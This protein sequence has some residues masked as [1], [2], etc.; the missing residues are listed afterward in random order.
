LTIHGCLIR[1]IG[2][3][4]QEFLVDPE[5]KKSSD[6][7]DD[8]VKIKKQGL[9]AIKTNRKRGKMNTDFRGKIKALYSYLY[10]RNNK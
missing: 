2:F 5:T 6:M 7:S 4:E 10:K 8:F 3:S 9:R 1:I